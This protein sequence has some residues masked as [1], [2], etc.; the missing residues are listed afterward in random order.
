MAPR[1]WDTTRSE[2]SRGRVRARE[3]KVQAEVART[4]KLLGDFEATPSLSVQQRGHNLMA[5]DERLPNR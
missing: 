4:K 3:D 1:S 2:K 5:A